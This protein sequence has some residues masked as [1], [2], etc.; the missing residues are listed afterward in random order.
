MRVSRVAES[1]WHMSSNINSDQK[2]L[3]PV[4]V[5]DGL[6]H[7]QFASAE[8]PSTIKDNDL[9]SKIA[10]QDAY[11]IVGYNMSSFMQSVLQA[12][13]MDSD[14]GSDNLLAPFLEAMYQEGSYAMKDACYQS[15]LVNVPTP[16]CLKGSPWVEERAL[17]NLV[18]DFADSEVTLKNDDNFHRASTVYPYHHPDISNSC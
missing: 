15:S 4:R 16:Q 14:A 8:P 10:D 18:G 13:V 11:S 5:I 6:S 7:Y 17:K 2:D 9:S 12:K 1:L 3:F